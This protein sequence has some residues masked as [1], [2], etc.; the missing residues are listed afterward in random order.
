MEKSRI[1]IKKNKGRDDYKVL[2]ICEKT[3]NIIPAFGLEYRGAIVLGQLLRDLSKS[4]M[5]LPEEMYIDG[6][7]ID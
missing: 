5:E 1:V 7:K 4:G 2:I 6:V 3:K